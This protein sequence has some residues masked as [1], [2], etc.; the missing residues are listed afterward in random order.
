MLFQEWQD[1]PMAFDEV[2]DSHY[3]GFEN[4]E[5]YKKTYPPRWN[6]VWACRPWNGFLFKPSM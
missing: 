6:W 5:E 2:Q 3:I 4:D 1:N